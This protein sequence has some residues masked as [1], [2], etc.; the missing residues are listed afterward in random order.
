MGEWCFKKRAALVIIVAIISSLQLLL[1]TA[2]EAGG[3]HEVW[4]SSSS[5]AGGRGG[6]AVV[7]PTARM[8]PDGSSSCSGEE[9]VVVYQ[10]SANPLPSGIPAY[11]VQII[12][13]CGGGCTVYDVHVSCGDFASTELV[14]P[15][16]FQRV[17]F[18]DCVVKGGAALEP[19]ETVSFQYSNSFSYQLSVASVACH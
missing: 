13:V 12:N 17:A 1:I 18:D 9:A 7:V 14:D 2:Q 19:S 5:P 8:G 15:A 3:D 4:S 6:G 11:T 10:S 16:K